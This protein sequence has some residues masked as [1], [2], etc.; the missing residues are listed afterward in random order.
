MIL[1]SGVNQNRYSYTVYIELEE[2]KGRF[3]K[4]PVKELELTTEGSEKGGRISETCNRINST[5]E[6]T[7]Q[8]RNPGRLSNF[9]LEQRDVWL[10]CILLYTEMVNT[11]R[12]NDSLKRKT[13]NSVQ[14]TLSFKC[15]WH[16]QINAC[17][18]Q[19]GGGMK[20]ICSV[21]PYE[22]MYFHGRQLSLRTQHRKWQPKWQRLFN[23]HS[24][25]LTSY[26]III[27][28]LSVTISTIINHNRSHFLHMGIKKS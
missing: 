17:I 24:M 11:T 2:S 3:V 15:P 7:S 20:C 12:K 5:W 27:S 9:R 16:N 6:I 8:G 23:Y 21:K 10:C 14:G 19:A 13:M 28:R 25:H 22:C 26:V 4:K 18:K 1:Q